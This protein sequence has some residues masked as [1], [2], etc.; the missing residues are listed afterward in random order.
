MP[1][2]FVKFAFIFNGRNTT[3]RGGSAAPTPGLPLLSLSLTPEPAGL[4]PHGAAASAARDVV[5][6][7]RELELPDADLACGGR[8]AT[9]ISV[10]TP[11]PLLCD[12]PARC[13]SNCGDA[14]HGGCA[15]A[16]CEN[17]ARVG[18]GPSAPRAGQTPA[19][20]PRGRCPPPPAPPPARRWGVTP[21]ARQ[22]AQALPPLSTPLRRLVCFCFEGGCGRRKSVPRGRGG[23]LFAASQ[24]RNSVPFSVC[25]QALDCRTAAHLQQGTEL[26][27]VEQPVLVLLGGGS[28]R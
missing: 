22:F 25:V 5:E 26:V 16:A 24:A 10:H 23:G 20:A 17:H 6:Q 8:R 14:S 9:P 3:R 21:S 28:G 13:N 27:A 19:A 7:S 2:T 11:S 4:R 18:C 12:R 1:Q 15:R